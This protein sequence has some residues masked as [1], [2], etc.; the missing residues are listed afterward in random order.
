VHSYEAI[1]S[2]IDGATVEHARRLHLSSSLLG[3]WQEACSD[4]TDSGCFN[5]LDRIETLVQTSLNLGTSQDKALAPV[6]YL[7]ERFGLVVLSIPCEKSSVRSCEKELLHVIEEFGDLARESAR[8]LDDG[9]IRRR[10]AENIKR[11][12]WEAI[13]QIARF[14]KLA[15]ESVR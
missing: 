2:A 15:G 12:G 10:E 14:V 1:H 8:A 9:A 3:K 11:E 6:Q 7:A 5:P 13:R 4:Y